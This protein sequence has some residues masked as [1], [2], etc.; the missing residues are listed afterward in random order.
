MQISSFMVPA[1]KVFKCGMDDTLDKVADLMVTNNV[2]CIVV[3]DHTDKAVGIVTK[4]DLVDAYRK[5]TPLDETADNLMRR[6]VDAIQKDA[7]RDSLASLFEKKHHHHAFV[8]DKHGEFVGLVSAWD[9]A[10][11]C[12]KDSRAWP[13]VRPIGEKFGLAH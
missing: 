4:T 11:E 5:K 8:V 12:A 2:S 10:A 13:W 7:P 3:F 1:D 9:V 6:E